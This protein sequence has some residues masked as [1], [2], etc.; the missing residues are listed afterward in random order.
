[1]TPHA[2]ATPKNLPL[3]IGLT[4]LAFLCLALISALAKAA[5]PGASS[6]ML[7]FFQFFISLVVL[8]PWMLRHGIQHLASHRLRLQL[9][10]SVF[11]MLSQLLLFVALNYIPLV[12]AVLL[13][14]SSPLFIPL[15]TW[16]WL[17]TRIGR[18][19]WISLLIGFVGIVLILQPGA[20]ALSWATPLALAAGICSAIGLTT[21][22]R[23]QNTEPPERTLFY[24]FLMSSVLALPLLVTS[25]K[26]PD[27]Q[28]WLILVGIGV[29]MALA[30]TFTILAYR[31]ASPATL[32]PFNYSVVVFSALIGWIVWQE[33]PN[34]LSYVG[35]LLVVVGGVLSTRH[36]APADG[37]P[38]AASPARPAPS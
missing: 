34:L 22:G 12:D 28:T 36:S 6:G 33:A 8:L 1:M 20:G 26:P 9:N 7:V 29:L 21:A 31:Q 11:G 16:A 17:K 5:S 13:A 14:N 3:G 38:P 19:L 24:F 30:Q 23:L 2:D 37:Q 25:W 35:A 32:A 10:W 18:A 15:V 4:L 27:P